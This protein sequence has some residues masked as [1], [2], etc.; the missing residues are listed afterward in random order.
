MQEKFTDNYLALLRM[1]D[2]QTALDTLYIRM[3][4]LTDVQLRTLE[5]NAWSELTD[6]SLRKTEEEAS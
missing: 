4:E 3:N 6:R 1:C 5:F 2:I